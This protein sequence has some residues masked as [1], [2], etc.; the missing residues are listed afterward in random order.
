MAVTCSCYLMQIL[1][2][3]VMFRNW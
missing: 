3:Y 1:S 2:M